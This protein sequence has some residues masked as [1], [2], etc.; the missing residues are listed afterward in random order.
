MAR[1]KGPTPRRQ[2]PRRASAH[3]QGRRRTSWLLALLAVA[4]GISVAAVVALT[5]DDGEGRISG[6]L[7]A[8]DP[9]PIHVHGLGINPSDGALFIATHTGLWRVP[10]TSDRAE[11]VTDRTQDTM[12]FT[13]VGPDLFLGSGHPD[14]RENL[15]PLLGLIESRDAGRSWEPISLLGEADFHV[16]RSKGDRVYGFD[17]SN[18]RLMLS[19][20]RGRTWTER[21][22]PGALLDLAVDPSLPRHFVASGER[23]L[24]ESKD[25]GRSW[26]QLGRAIGLLVWPDRGH[27]YLVDQSGG[28]SLSGDAGRTWKAVGAVGGQPAA[29]M[30]R[31]Q[32]E[33]YVAVHDGTIMRSVDGGKS[34]AV[35]SAAA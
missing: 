10:P 22:P 18:G 20:D 34:W 3:S 30:A 15:P 9:G 26:R 27:L 28:V 35:R 1:R 33:L 17:S 5:R 13:V 21:K 14:V 4:G 29:L 31:S 16:L 12:G 25:E 7:P 24:L 2:D 8:S 19:S 6:Q 32:N 11:R 23:G